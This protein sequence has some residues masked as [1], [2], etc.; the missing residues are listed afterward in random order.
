M[1]NSLLA[2]FPEPWTPNPDWGYLILQVGPSWMSGEASWSGQWSLR[3]SCWRQ[4]GS[5]VQGLGAV[6]DVRVGGVGLGFGALSS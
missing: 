4:K 3:R 5:K 1:I 6:G 2:T